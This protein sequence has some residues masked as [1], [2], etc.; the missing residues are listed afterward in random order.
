MGKFRRH[1]LELKDCCSLSVCMFITG[2]ISA[3]SF[4]S[5]GCHT[6]IKEPNL[7]SNLP[8]LEGEKLD[9]FSK[10][11]MLCEMQT[12]SLRNWTRIAESTTIT[13]RVLPLQ[14]TWKRLTGNQYTAPIAATF[15]S[16]TSLLKKYYD[17][18]QFKWPSWNLKNWATKIYCTPAY[19]VD[20][21]L[22]D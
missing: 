4:S 10:V 7:P 6:K 13:L 3:I 8:K 12:V 16:S 19:S 22:S 21:T 15:M 18:S 14:S 20:C 2:L 5:T 1:F 17:N 9:S 11:W